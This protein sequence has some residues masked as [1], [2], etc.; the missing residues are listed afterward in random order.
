MYFKKIETQGIAHY[1]YMVGDEDFIAVIDP[2]RDV[3]IY[4]QEARKAGMRI[5]YILETHR[6]EDY[7][8]GARELGD[9]TGANIYISGHEDLGYV[10]GE[11]IEDGFELKIG[12]VK[13][14]AIHTPG[15]TMGHLS[16]ALYERDKLN[17]YMVFTGDCL[18]MGDAGRTDFYGKS[19]LEKMTGLLYDSIFEK[20]LPLGDEVLMFPAHGA[21]SACGESM[22]E[23]PFSTI[24]YEIRHNKLLQVDSKGQFIDD[25]AKMRIKPRYFEKMEELNVK[26]ADFVGQDIVLNAFTFEEIKQLK[27]EVLLLDIRS[28][29]AHIGGHIPGSIYMSKKSISTFL[30]AIFKTDEKILF[31]IDDNIGELEEIY[32]YCKRIGFDNILGY[33]PNASSQWENNGEELEKVSTISAKKYRETSRDSEFML[34][35]IRKSDEIEDTDPHENR[36]NIPLHNIYKCLAHLSYDLPTFVLCNSGERATIG[37]SYLKRK[38]YNPIVITGGV[39]MLEALNEK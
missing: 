22:D 38:G 31:V 1:S 2:V 37:Y 32:C 11:K 23:R 12:E 24:G 13:L 6:N 18:F 5:K 10:F 26:G 15:H 39:K 27:E 14:K 19:N 25:F 33:F 4:M 17:P 35:D 8:S 16:Y 20:L 30:G 29:E 7:V 21:G 34:L 28:K 36:V 3:G 9:K